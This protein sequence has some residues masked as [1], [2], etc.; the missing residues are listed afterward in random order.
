VSEL[1]EEAPKPSPSVKFTDPPPP[2]FIEKITTPHSPGGRNASS[3]QIPGSGSV[4]KSSPHTPPR[5]PHN[6]QSPKK[7][8]EEEEKAGSDY[9][10]LTLT[11]KELKEAMKS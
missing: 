3:P 9:H 5:S 11:S 1:I 7:K 4:T 2:I 6:Y 8:E 10:G